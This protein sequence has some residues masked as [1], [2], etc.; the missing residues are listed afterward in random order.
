MRWPRSLYTNLSHSVSLYRYRTFSQSIIIRKLCQ[1]SKQQPEWLLPT[2]VIEEPVLRVY[3]SLTRTKVNLYAASPTTY[4]RI[5]A[6]DA[7]C[8]SERTTCQVV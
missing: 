8:A 3:N 5:S 7:V 2:N 6:P 1:M 4:L